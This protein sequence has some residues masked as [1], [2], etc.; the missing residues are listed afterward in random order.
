MNNVIT[1]IDEVY[2]N[3]SKIVIDAEI[4][5]DRKIKIEIGENEWTKSPILLCLTTYNNIKYTKLCIE[6]INLHK[7]KMVDVV[8][9]DD[10]STDET[11][12]W[13]EENKISVIQKNEG[14][15]LTDSWN[16]A[17]RLFK[18]LDYE[19][20][21]IANND[22]I[23]PD[24]A[25]QEMHDVYKKWPFTVVVPLSNKIGAGHSTQQRIN[26]WYSVDAIEYSDTQ[27]IQNLLLSMKNEFFKKNDIYLLDPLRI[28]FF[29]GFFFMFSRNVIKYERDDKNLFPPEF[30]MD[31]AEDEFNWSKLIPENDY[32]ALCKTS[33]VYHFKGTTINKI[34][35]YREIANDKN[36]IFKERV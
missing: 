5:K 11:V 32:P 10:F 16:V 17:Y 1:A 26:Q 29:N 19:Y 20:L 9:I 31:K 13:C 23:I 22:I 15:G 30:I 33:F 2:K 18:E 36:R 3:L 8:V 27:N 24:G 28:K 6:S 25:I 7:N 12:K 14:K 34:N 21:I 4:N 35:N